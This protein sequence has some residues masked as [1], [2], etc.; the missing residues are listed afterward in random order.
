M[1]KVSRMLVVTIV[2]LLATSMSIAQIRAEKRAQK[3]IPETPNLFSIRAI[4][5]YSHD[6]NFHQLSDIPVLGIGLGVGLGQEVLS[7]NVEMSGKEFFSIRKTDTSTHNIKIGIPAAA[8]GLSVGI[9]ATWSTLLAQTGI[10]A[11]GRMSWTN[12]TPSGKTNIIYGWDFYTHL[13]INLF[14]FKER[15]SIGIFGDWYI[16]NMLRYGKNPTFDIT[17]SMRVGI[18][19]RIHQDPCGCQ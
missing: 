16:I 10:G 18:V 1:K 12:Q 4:G 5:G 17:N 3:T 14:G 8:A 2:W 13:Q 9:P 6:G 11:D 15:N 19:C 7:L